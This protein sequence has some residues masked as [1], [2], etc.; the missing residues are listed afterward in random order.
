MVCVEP[1]T[2][3]F[4]AFTNRTEE[5]VHILFAAVPYGSS[6]FPKGA[7]ISPITVTQ[8]FTSFAQDQSI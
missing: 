2:K 6:M 5:E 7:I 4:V 8:F 1:A 3:K